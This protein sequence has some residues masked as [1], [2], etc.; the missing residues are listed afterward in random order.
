[1]NVKSFVVIRMVNVVFVGFFV[2]VVIVVYL[3]LVVMIVFFF[4]SGCY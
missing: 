1:M 4:N 2:L 3:F